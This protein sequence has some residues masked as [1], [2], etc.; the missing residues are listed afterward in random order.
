MSISI[1][2]RDIS[3]SRDIVQSHTADLDALD[4]LANSDRL[5]DDLMSHTDGHGSLTPTT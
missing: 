2:S 4:I 1:G 5:P 3:W